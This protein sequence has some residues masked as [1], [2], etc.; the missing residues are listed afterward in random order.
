MKKSLTAKLA[1]SAIVL[2]FGLASAQA[3]E[4]VPVSAA[5]GGNLW[6]V[7]LSGNPTIDGG[8]SRAVGAEQAAFM[9]AADAD[10][11]NFTQRRSFS[12]LFNGYSVEIDAANRAKLKQLP[13]VKAIWPVEVIQ[14]PLVERMPG[15]AAPDL[16]AAIRMTGANVAQDSLGLTGK[17]IKVAVMDTGIDYDHPDL[18][19][20]FGPG[21]RVAFGYDLVGDAFNADPTAAS[22]NPIPT[23]DND[24]DDCAGHG[25]HV[26]G[27]V[28]AKGVVKGVAPD[29]TFGAYRVFG[30][31]GSTTADIMIEAM[32][33]ALK[34]GMQ[35][36]NMSIG[37][38]FQWPDYPTAV[39]ARRLNKEGVVVVASI[40][41]S[42]TSG[43]YAAG[44][45]GVGDAVLG[46]ASFDNSNVTLS[47]FT[48]NGTRI[49]YIPMTFAGPTPVSGDET[50][51]WVGVG[52]AC[53]PL[54]VDL[55][56]K[57]ALAA[58]GT[59]S[60]GTK[61][62]NA[63]NAGAKAVVIHNNAAGVFSGT[64]GAPID[65]TTPVVGISLADGNFI[66]AQTAPVQMT[67]AAGTDLFANPTGGLISSF[68]SY[69]LAADLSIKPN[70]G[71]P[72]GSIYSTYPLELGGYA[73]LSGTSMASPHAAGGAALL[74]QADRWVG[75]DRVRRNLQNSADP[76]V[77]GG[78]PGLGFLDNVH[79]Q[80][81][82]MLDIP[83]A[84]QVTTRVEPSE[85]ALGES[86]AGP[87]VTRRL[88]IKNHGWSP[89]TY[90]LS[91]VAALSTGGTRAPSFF[92]SDASAS[93]SPAVVNLLPWGKVDL[94]VTITPATGPVA[95]LYGGYIVLTDAADGTKVVRVPYAGFVGDYQSIQV[96]TPAIPALLRASV[97]GEAGR[98]FIYEPAG[99]C[100]LLDG[101]RRHP[102]LPAAP[103]PPVVAHG[104]EVWNADQKQADSQHQY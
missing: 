36:L 89:V 38:S 8:S 100:Q 5:E 84:I 37:S 102:V 12:T 97:A 28:G 52:I 47:Y 68:S 86:E 16:A 27:I 91:H 61:A 33:L 17:G 73:T 9:R 83:G 55:T 85:L 44:A 43:L 65:G 74:R 62:V 76:K 46:V 63:I 26:A 99:W 32:E 58:R 87:A 69:G 22:Y 31:E 23:P 79:R 29:V 41:N 50:I 3:Q 13:G 6:F 34:D 30:C 93:F 104:L 96:L 1:A 81:A 77:W 14:M 39:A 53:D 82:G 72:G 71:A 11:V 101:W 25:T 7:E 75:A 40:G 51:E 54:A 4:A 10:G 64:L 20:C 35:V 67:W 103:R 66:K 19:G 24:P 59:C 56:G 80:G 92:L 60:F 78:N 98:R 70:I 94:D 95:G 49:G 88:T 57:V 90:N 48:V 18:G 21:C 15:G 45:P 2:S 42:G